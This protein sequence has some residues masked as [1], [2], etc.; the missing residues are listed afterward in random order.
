MSNALTKVKR[1]QAGMR[2]V[3]ESIDK[4]ARAMCVLKRQGIK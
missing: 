2:V 1:H 4:R 3:P